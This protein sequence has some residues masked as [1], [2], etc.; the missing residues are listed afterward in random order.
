MRILVKACNGSVEEA[1]CVQQAVND[2]LLIVYLNL[3]VAYLNLLID[4]LRLLLKNIVM[5][6]TNRLRERPHKLNHQIVR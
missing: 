1:D 5:L 4:Y 3:L 2:Q 6:L